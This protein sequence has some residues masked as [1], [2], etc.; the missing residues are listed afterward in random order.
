[1]DFAIS[2]AFRDSVHHFLSNVKVSG[3]E[4]HIVSSLL[5]AF[6]ESM[7]VSPI[8]KEIVDAMVQKFEAPLAPDAPS[9][10]AP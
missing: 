7:H 1:M 8:T 9:E 5:K 4:T 10:K 2:K 3:V 6:D